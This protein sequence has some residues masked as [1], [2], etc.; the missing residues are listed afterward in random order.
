[1]S[2][3]EST[4]NEPTSGEA[5]ELLHFEEVQQRI[6]EATDALPPAC[7]TIFVLSRH[8]NMSYK[9]I[10]EALQISP[11]TVENQMG[12]ALKHFREYLNVYIKHLL[13]FLL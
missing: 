7:K 13:S 1:V 2:L 12:K 6:Q 8:E 3:E 10:A 4:F 11:K 5:D 9:E